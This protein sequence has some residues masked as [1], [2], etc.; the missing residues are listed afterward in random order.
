MDLYKALKVYFGYDT[1]KKGQEKLIQGIL[2]GRDALGIMPTGGGKSL[3]YQLPGILLEGITI[4]ISPLISLMKDQVDS[5]KE[6]GVEATYINSTLE[7][8]E[9][10]IRLQEIRENKYKILYV[11]PERLNT[12]VFKELVREIEVSLVA[13]DEAHCISQWGHDFRPSYLEIPRFIK[14]L[15]VRPVVAAFT[16]TAT[17][18]VLEEIK[19]LIELMAPLES[20][21]G[22]DR[23]N[24]FYEVVKTA[25][26][27]SYLLNY[28]N[29]NF[30]DEAGIIYCATRKTV[31]SLVKRL[32]E[33]GFSVA[34]YHGG[35]TAE[36]RQK[37]QED[38]ML[39]N[40]RI[41]VATNAFGMGIDKPDVRFVIHYN[42][43]QNMEAYYQEAGRAGRDGEKSHCILMYSA[44]DIIK[45]KLILQNDHLAQ[46]R[47]EI[48]Y[49]NLQ[50]LVD[51]CH[52]NDCLRNHILMYF[53]ETIEEENCNNCSNCS[54]EEE[55]VDITIEAQKILSCIY[56]TNQ[57]YG[58]NMV[59]QVLRGSKN[60]R[61]LELGFD[62]ISTY[63]IMKDYSDNAIR[64][65]IMILA[66]EG[67]IHI[68]TDRF[69][70]LKLVSKSREVLR[71]EVQVY[72]K[73]QLLEKKV[74]LGSKKTTT[75]RDIQVNIDEELF[76]ELR[77]ARYSIAKDKG[78]APFMI[79]HDASLKEMA[80]YFPQNKE[81]FL[82]I[83]GIG[84]KKYENYGEDFIAIIKEHIIEKGIDINYYR[85]QRKFPSEEKEIIENNHHNRYETTYN[86]YE[87]G[88]S[89]KEIASERGFTERT[90][91][92]HLKK[93]HEDGKVVEWERFVDASIEKEILYVI[94]KVGYQKLKPIKD[95]LPEEISYVDIHLVLAKNGLN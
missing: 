95:G 67:Y 66:A 45:Q 18:D 47:E 39:N 6:V 22:F 86:Y 35:M 38:F 92:N 64:E 7:D 2:R 14:N 81:E 46:G 4:V 84:M 24:L 63:G 53:S 11:A 60:K 30:Q 20:I 42:M 54:Y 43:P 94:E 23:P 1:F 50:Y 74:S 91:I 90:I 70:V 48:L 80:A 68:T 76:E 31:E 33:K 52:T 72:H 16:A 88:L 9:F 49:R 73:K 15:R 8:E 57:S 37:N 56:R 59:I 3:C 69:P 21:T 13:V 78:L 85:N 77:K 27:F 75:K 29:T 55:M 61:V 65:M 25:D 12:Q 51:Y 79:F 19:N 93:C 62:K 44:S 40:T 89:L 5:L 41:I 34:G 71:G 32:Q 28:L 58:G 17:K 83:S 87:K 36:I 10:F 82:A 26:K